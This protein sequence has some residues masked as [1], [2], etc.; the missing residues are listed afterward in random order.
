M[1]SQRLFGV[2]SNFSVSFG[3]KPKLNNKSLLKGKNFSSGSEGLDIQEGL[4]YGPNRN[5]ASHGNFGRLA[6]GYV[7]S[8]FL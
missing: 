8:K 6:S 3:P 4:M 5:I 7:S 2:E 1:R